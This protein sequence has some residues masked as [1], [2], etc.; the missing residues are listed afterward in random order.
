MPTSENPKSL[1]LKRAFEVNHLFVNGFDH[2]QQ[3][4]AQ[5]HDI[6]LANVM[7]FTTF[8]IDTVAMDAIMA[9]LDR[10]MQLIEFLSFGQNID[11]QTY[12]KKVRNFFRL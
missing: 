2:A 11:T 5:T 8:P 12:P 7:K 10:A 3:H 1:N 4:L 6:G 9:N